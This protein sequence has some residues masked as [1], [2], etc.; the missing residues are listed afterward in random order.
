MSIPL[1]DSVGRL[2]QN[3][4]DI[5][6]AFKYFPDDEACRRQAVLIASDERERFQAGAET[7]KPS[8]LAK[9]VTTWA[10]KRSGQLTV[11]GYA[12]LAFILLL[13]KGREEPTLYA[14]AKVVSSA[15]AKLKSF[16]PLPFKSFHFEGE[17]SVRDQRVP[18]STE[19]IMK[20]F[21]RYRFVVHLEAADIAASEHFLLMHIFNRTPETM[22]SSIRTAHAI[23]TVLAQRMQKDFR[24]FWS[25]GGC[26]TPSVALVDPV[27]IEGNVRA[28]LESGLD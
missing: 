25:V 9:A 5:W 26:L 18:S 17:W 11:A 12:A 8:A 3:A 28:F 24:D 16:D 2:H 7:W 4:A 1:V 14:S 22:L 27:Y 21:G 19:D 15:L 10:G 20:A 13:E 23:E 6:L